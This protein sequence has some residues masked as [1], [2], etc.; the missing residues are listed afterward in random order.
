[1]DGD[2]AQVSFR[3][4]ASE[5]MRFEAAQATLRSHDLDMSLADVLRAAIREVTSYVE[6]TYSSVAVNDRD[7]AQQAENAL[8]I[9]GA[10]QH[11]SRG[12]VEEWGAEGDVDGQS[13]ST[14]APPFTGS[15]L[16]QENSGV[17][18]VAGGGQNG[19]R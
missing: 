19:A 13:T 8:G 11:S 9:P 15:S 1:M 17:G 10:V 6:Q 16:T 4:A 18:L 2:Q 14:G 5:K 12:S 3:L 7:E